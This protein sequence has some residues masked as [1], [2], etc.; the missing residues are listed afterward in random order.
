MF[1]GLGGQ[2]EPNSHQH[3]RISEKKIFHE[4]DVHHV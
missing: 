3:A 4:T 1:L 2:N